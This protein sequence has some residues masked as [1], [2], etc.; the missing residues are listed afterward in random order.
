MKWPRNKQI[1]FE[2]FV[3]WHCVQYILLVYFFRPVSHPSIEFVNTLRL[4]VPQFPHRDPPPGAI[5][6]DTTFDRCSAP[7]ADF[8]GSRFHSSAFDEC[9][10]S[11]AYVTFCS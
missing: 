1:I 5:F 4:K 7:K 6:R 11:G 9:D 10:L 3:L 8:S 2:F